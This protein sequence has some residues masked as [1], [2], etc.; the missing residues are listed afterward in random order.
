M[1]TSDLSR[2]CGPIPFDLWEEL[3]LF[4]FCNDIDRVAFW[5]LALC[6]AESGQVD[7]TLRGIVSSLDDHMAAEGLADPTGDTTDAAEIERLKARVA[8]VMTLRVA[9]VKGG[10]A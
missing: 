4:V 5:M 7:F 3:A 8:E 6:H 10:D 1:S 2:V 9:T